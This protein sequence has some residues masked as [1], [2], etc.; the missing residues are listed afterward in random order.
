VLQPGFGDATDNVMAQIDGTRVC[1]ASYRY[2]NDV[3]TSYSFVADMPLISWAKANAKELAELQAFMLANKAQHDPHAR[4][5]FVSRA[6]AA[7]PTSSLLCS[8]ARRNRRVGGAQA[9]TRFA[10][11]DR[12]TRIREPAAQLTSATCGCTRRRVC[13][14]RTRVSGARSLRRRQCADSDSGHRMLDNHWPTSR[15]APAVAVFIDNRP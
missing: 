3:R 7:S 11:R 1:H 12:Q 6:G 8:A 2:R 5:R 4:D 15:I 14:E 13:N 9:R 10:R